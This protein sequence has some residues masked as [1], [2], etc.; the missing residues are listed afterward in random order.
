MR[1]TIIIILFVLSTGCAGVKHQPLNF[2]PDGIAFSKTKIN[3]N[4]RSLTLSSA[5]PNE[6]TGHIEFETRI[7]YLQ[8]DP[9]QL[10]KNSLQKAID[11]MAIFSDE[12]KRYVSL[13]VTIK[14]F[15]VPTSGFDRI[16]H[17]EAKY[18]II[19]RKNG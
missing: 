1:K 18:Q 19:N 6:A 12:S 4:L 11:V 15:E 8:G 13:T 17:V 3:A 16:S 5:G 9:R 7:A 14:K 2:Y 10:W